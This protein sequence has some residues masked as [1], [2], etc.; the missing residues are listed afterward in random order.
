MNLE[1][2]IKD[3]LVFF[4]VCMHTRGN[5]CIE[6]D[7]GSSENPELISDDLVT[8]TLARERSLKQGGLLKQA[9]DVKIDLD[10]T[11][12]FV[13]VPRKIRRI[14]REVT[15]GIKD[16]EKKLDALY[17]RLSDEFKSSYVPFDYVQTFASY[18]ERINDKPNKNQTHNIIK[19]Y[20]PFIKRR[21]RQNADKHDK[22]D[23]NR[24]FDRR[25]R[26]LLGEYLRKRFRPNSKPYTIALSFLELAAEKW[27]PFFCSIW[28]RQGLNKFD[29]HQ[30]NGS[31]CFQ[32][33]KFMRN[34]CISVGLPAAIVIG[35]E[36]NDLK[37][38]HAW[39]CVKT[40]RWQHVDVTHC[41]RELEDYLVA[42]EFPSDAKVLG[43]K[44][45]VPPYE[46]DDFKILGEYKICSPSLALRPN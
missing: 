25:M 31:G 7:P 26:F 14:A 17:E 11:D 16:K 13:R 43:A 20:F 1:L 44:L 8:H 35:Y 2:K 38:R 24:W 3:N 36:P 10:L 34:A 30:K 4:P 15:K 46:Y 23:I 39:T 6:L 12:R 21:L 40:D 41:V 9:Y 27:N 29:Y 18:I 33:S 42:F 5:L 45:V 19:S 28:D 32:K 37:G 22:R